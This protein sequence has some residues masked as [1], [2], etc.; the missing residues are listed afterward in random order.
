MSCRIN[1]YNFR[2][3]KTETNRSSIALKAVV[4][5]LVAG[6]FFK[7]KDDKIESLKKEIGNFLFR[8]SENLA[9]YQ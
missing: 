1:V 2:H 3:Q 5:V 7:S 4:P 6:S 9:F 8:S